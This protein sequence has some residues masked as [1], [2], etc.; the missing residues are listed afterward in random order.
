MG[1][2]KYIRRPK[3]TSTSGGKFLCTN[4]ELIDWGDVSYSPGSFTI[5][6]ETSK[7]L[8]KTIKLTTDQRITIE[9]TGRLRIIT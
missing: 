1:I 7:T 4:G 3:S 5:A 9:G 2:K 8:G 6:T